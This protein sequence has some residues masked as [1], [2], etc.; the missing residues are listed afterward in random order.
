MAKI[1]HIAMFTLKDGVD[2]SRI[3]AALDLLRDNVP[4]PTRSIYGPDA[5][6]RAGNASYG[7]SY[8]FADETTYMTWDKDPEHDRIR[9]E[10]VAP[11]VSAVQRCQFRIND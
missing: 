2:A 10:L 3:T 5:G 7:A 4:G 6:L 8:D 9:R 11:H 1:R